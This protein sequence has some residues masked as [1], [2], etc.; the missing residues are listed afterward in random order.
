[1]RN[2]SYGVTLLI[3]RM[4]ESEN[5]LVRET[6]L[7]LTEEAQ[8]L[9]MNE[10]LLIGGNAVIAY[11]VPRFTRDVDFVIPERVK[12]VW[13]SFLEDLG[14]QLIH[15][16]QAFLQFEDQENSKPRVDLMVV[17][18]NT[19]EKL[20]ARAYVLELG[21]SIS[22]EVAAPDHIIAMKLAACQ[23][24]HRRSDAIDWSDVVEL[25]IRRGFDPENDQEFSDL[26]LRYGGELLL[27]KLVDEINSRKES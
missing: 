10:F 25:T 8:K 2:D 13:R 21:E 14:F 27:G 6:L 20:N 18:E 23:S 15:G 17:D 26:V 9:E 4:G 16:T 5:N 11:G 19:W 12:N 7:F 1:M 22:A 3:F 24:P